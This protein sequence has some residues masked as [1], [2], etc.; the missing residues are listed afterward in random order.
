M[1][2]ARPFVAIPAAEAAV[3]YLENEDI[4]Q[5]AMKILANN[6]NME[7]SDYYSAI[8]ALNAIDRL[9]S[10]G[11]FDSEQLQ[12]IKELPT[13][14]GKPKRGGSYVKQLLEKIQG[15]STD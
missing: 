9:N 5:Q 1:L 4:Q 2:D 14:N 13:G 8:E 3:T 6:A 11:R 12:A 10:A 15:K 7:K